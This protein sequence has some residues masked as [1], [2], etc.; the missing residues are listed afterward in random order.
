MDA[1]DERRAGHAF[2]FY[3]SSILV[4]KTR[5]RPHS[6]LEQTSILLGG[7]DPGPRARFQAR[8]SYH[9]P[10]LTRHFLRSRKS[11]ILSPSQT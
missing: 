8:V 6:D 1:G 5:A 11:V 4:G 3:V 9:N 2:G 7:H 10:R